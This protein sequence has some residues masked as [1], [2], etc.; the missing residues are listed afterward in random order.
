MG[1]A[2]PPRRSRRERAR[3]PP[4]S[5]SR[6]QDRHPRRELDR[7]R[8]GLLRRAPRGGV[9]RAPADDGVRRFARAHDDRLAAR[10]RSSSSGAYR[11]V[12]ARDCAAT[13]SRCA[14]SFDGDAPPTSADALV[15][16]VPRARRPAPPPAVADRPDDAFDVIYSSGT[17]GVPKGIVHSHAARKA[18]Y[19]GS[20]ASY[21]AAD[22]VNVLAT[23]FYSNTT[24]VTWFITTARG[25]TNV[26]LGKFSP[27]ALLDAV[28]RHRVDARDARARCSTSASS[29]SRALRVDG[30]LEPALP[31][32]DERAARRRDQA[33]HSRR[34]PGGARGDLRAHRGRARSRSSRRARHPDKLASVGTPG[35]A[36][37][38]SASSTRPGA[39]CPPGDAG[40]VVGR[41]PNMMSGYLNRP[42]D[43]EAML[44]RDDERRA[45]LPHPETSGASTRTASSTCSI[46][47]RTSSSPAASTSTRRTSR[48][49]SRGTPR[50]PRSR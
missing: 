15:R 35:A 40:E 30:S 22:S 10:A 7:V 21:F 33:P 29:R 2:R 14:S 28:E 8:R 38:R 34:D 18:S 47:R 41:S 48:A 9:R 27:E 42:D 23:P 44:F 36:A 24:S 31:L 4:A 17:T 46:A 16:R 50:S 39:T 37:S 13:R 25:G 3:S 11:D 12:G 26:I 6:R 1:G 5:R 49:C 45:L 32:L 20:R 43:T 19:G